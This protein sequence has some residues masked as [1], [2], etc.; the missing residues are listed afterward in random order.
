MPP[1]ITNAMR[2]LI[3][4][5]YN[6]GKHP[7]VICSILKVPLKQFTGLFLRLNQKGR[8]I[9]HQKGEIKGLCLKAAK[10]TQFVGGLMVMQH[11]N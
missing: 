4:T 3:I 10:K 9:Q 8:F 1:N 11:S 5:N 6:E 7:K 2:E